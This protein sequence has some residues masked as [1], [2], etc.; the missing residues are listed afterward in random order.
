MATDA[1]GTPTSLG[2]PKFNTSVDA[3]SGLGANAM[4]DEIDALIAARIAKPSS[5]TTGDALV[6]N[7]TSWDKSSGA[8]KVAVAGLAPGSDDQVL[9]T[10]AGVPAWAAGGATPDFLGAKATHSTTQ[11]LGASSTLV[12]AFDSEDFDTNAL[13]DPATNNSRLTI[14]ASQDG[15]YMMAAYYAQTAAQTT[16]VAMRLRKNGTTTVSQNDIGGGGL[17]GTVLGIDNLVATDY[18]E[19]VVVNGDTSARTVQNTIWLAVWKVG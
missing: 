5:P 7:G 14:P 18:V 3:P 9:T 19:L 2:I 10:V 17:E 12:V 16:R 11:T 8:T 4:M 15:Y 1:T 13:H 6:W